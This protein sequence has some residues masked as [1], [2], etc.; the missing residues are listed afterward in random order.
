ML[1]DGQQFQV[2]ETILNQITQKTELVFLCNPNNPTGQ[3]IEPELLSAIAKRCEQTGTYLILDE[4]FN[5]F[6]DEPKRYSLKDRLADMQHLVIL[7]AFTK[8]YAMAGLRLGYALCA[9]KELLAKIE[10]V[11]QPWSV[12]VPAQAAGV[13]AAKETEYAHQSQRQ[14]SQAKNVLIKGL[15]ECGISVIGGAAN[16]LFFKAQ[17][18]LG[19]RLLKKNIL[20]RDCSNYKGLKEGYFRVAV[21]TP[22]D[23]EVLVQAVRS[24]VKGD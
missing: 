7:K 15:E 9:N 19:E 12:S 14:L 5:D 16:Y 1:E 21:R 3:L 18:D 13:A 11:R 6:L 17:P 23:N 20:I 2:D 10:T 24:I 8:M 22:K 4:C